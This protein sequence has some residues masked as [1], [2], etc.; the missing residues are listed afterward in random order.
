MHTLHTREVFQSL[1]SDDADTF[2][3][4]WGLFEGYYNQTKTIRNTGNRLQYGFIS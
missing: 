4:F 1:L 2:I 3:L